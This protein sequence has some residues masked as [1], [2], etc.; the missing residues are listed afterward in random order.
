MNDG[1]LYYRSSILR[2]RIN[3]CGIYGCLQQVV[4]N[5]LILWTPQSSPNENDPYFPYVPE[6]VNKI[7]LPN[8]L[9]LQDIISTEKSTQ[10]KSVNHVLTPPTSDSDTL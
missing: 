9:V 1:L 2:F 10:Q 5:P 7:L 4:K 8:E 6:P 3:V